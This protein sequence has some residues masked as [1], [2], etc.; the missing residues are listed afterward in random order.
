MPCLPEAVRRGIWLLA[1]QGFSP[2]LQGGL[3]NVRKIHMSQQRDV[4]TQWK[5]DVV[6]QMG[7]R[8]A[9]PGLQTTHFISSGAGSASPSAK[10]FL[11]ERPGVSEALQN[12]AGEAGI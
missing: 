3:G 7:H 4:A 8:R 11:A 1:S 12:G 9:L 6:V 10:P 5:G 2:Q